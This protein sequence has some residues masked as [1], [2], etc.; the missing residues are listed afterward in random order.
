[1]NQLYRVFRILALVLLALI[2]SQLVPAWK[3]RV[4][5]QSP[6]NEFATVYLPII[7]APAVDAWPMAGAN[8][9]RTSWTP[10]E[11]KGALK[12]AWY[13]QFEPYIPPSFQIIAANNTLFISTS[14]GL[15]AL[16][17]GSGA[18]KWVYPTE[19]PLGNS[20]TIYKNIAFVGG[21]DH[22]LHAI[23][24]STGQGM[25][26]FQAGSG[27]D[28]SPLVV[29][30]VVYLGNRDGSFYAVYAEGSNAG[31]LAWKFPTGGPIDY[32]AA[33]KDGIVYFASNDSYAYALNAQ[34]GALIWKSAKL[35]GAGFYTWWPVVYGDWVIFAG[36]EN[37]R[38]DIK[39][40]PAGA[41]SEYTKLELSDVYPNHMLDPKGTL[42]GPLGSAP[43]GWAANT[44]TIDASK[45]TVTSN[46]STLPITQYLEKKPW[47][48]TVFVLNAKTG[49]EYTTDFDGDHQVE[50]A[51]ILWQGTQ[52]GTRYP[53]VIGADNI[54]YITNNYESDPYIAG[55]NVAG[56]EFGTPFI[57]IISSGWKAVDEPIAYSAG[58]NVI[59]WD[60]C[61]D[62]GAGAIDTSI[63]DT[64]FADRYNAGARP[65]TGSLSPN[66]E[67][68]YFNYNLSQLIPGYSSRYYDVSS[69]NDIYGVFGG[70]DG[71][72]GSHGSQNPPIPYNGKVYIQR[73]N[74][75]IA[76]A[77]GASQVT[78]LPMAQIVKPQ[79]PN[80]PVLVK[81]KAT[82]ELVDQVNKMIAAGH[83]RPGY[84]GTGIFDLQGQSR[85]GDNLVDYWHDPGEVIVTLLNALPYLQ[86][87][88]QTQ[89][90]NYIQAEFA[91]YPPY[92][93]SHIGWSGGVAREAFDL[94]PEVNNDRANFPAQ[95][96][97]YGYLGWNFN[98]YGF[99]A[100]W[101][102]AQEFGGARSIF[103]AG[104]NN[105][106]T[107]PADA[108]LT[109]FPQV[110]NAYIAGYMGYL[111]LQQL[112]YNT[113]DPAKQNIL[114]HL[115]SLRKSTF[116]I[117]SASLFY[118]DRSYS[119]C[120]TLN[121]SANF[122]YL[123][124]EVAQ[125]LGPIASQVQTAVTEYSQLEPYWF[126]SKF[127]VTF[128]EGA[129]QPFYDYHSLFQAK[130]LI[131]GASQVELGK[132][133][134]IPSVAVGDLFYID[135]LV[136][137]L[138][139]P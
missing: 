87:D 31:Q 130:A 93:Y 4:A 12:P 89:V 33:Y 129:F 92:A 5:A 49:K 88:L 133:L 104:K 79:N 110:N 68:T 108:Y 97:V 15:Y 2:L 60:L 61:C 56:W 62:R 48:R 40:G 100:A 127:G 63:P 113:Q 58:G 38:T 85:C 136:A 118:T 99:Y 3:H 84:S 126:V 13:K 23:N 50:Y 123:V 39:P 45:A 66:R 22:L 36:S 124:P 137:F 103:D 81:A 29:N 55:G 71:V 9:E 109:E 42:V 111:G 37:Y 70:R 34:T 57:S 78:A 6:V 53:P 65:A 95:T 19:M 132:Y 82:G 72:Y 101:K 10:E 67:W 128:G 51:P 114:N 27:F 121:T 102:Y 117:D 105:L 134:D 41:I 30:G 76:F 107:P 7:R 54:V 44:P 21:F 46:G 119:Y 73:S 80:T 106:P 47:R 20:P 11:I 131:L 112:A 122:L 24:A 91:A 86:A 138:Q 59:Y 64:A 96:Y 94:P 125:Q 18:Q 83:L 26:T 14:A 25:W 116:L 52:G 135:N 74:A 17:A 90:I 16:D 98:P 139:A 28:T 120:R 77:P 1:M 32:S 8:P 35:P 115:I 43:G 75:V 69:S